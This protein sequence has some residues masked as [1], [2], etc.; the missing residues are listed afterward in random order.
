MRFSYEIV[1]TAG[2]NLMTADTL[3]RA[4]GSV[5]AE[6]ERLM[7]VETHNHVCSVLGAI[8]AS[9]A[10][11][12]EIRQKQLDDKICSQDIT[13][14]KVDH[15]PERAKK[16]EEI[17]PYWLVRQ[18]LS[19]QMG[20]LLYQCRLVIPASLQEDILQRLHQGH[21][22][23]VKCRALARESVWWPGLS[24]RMEKVVEA[25]PTCEKDRQ[26]PED[27]HARQSQ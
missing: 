13:F 27:R 15:W 16:D 2:K 3:S 4:P 1:H 26:Y 7:E 21:Q 22:G 14:C 20:L 19:V 24:K 5:P 8:P 9:D 18:D 17:R 12:E 25:C 23:I 10:R 6:Q 11:L